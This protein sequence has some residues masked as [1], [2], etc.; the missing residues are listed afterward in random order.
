M[1]FEI[2]N[3]PSIFL[4]KNQMALALW[5]HIEFTSFFHNLYTFA[6]LLPTSSLIF[7]LFHFLLS[8]KLQFL[9]FL[10]SLMSPDIDHVYYFPFIIF[11]S[12]ATTA[13]QDDVS[14]E[15]M[16]KYVINV[17]NWFLIIIFFF[18]NILCYLKK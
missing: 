3:H 18:F 13:T 12:Y 10:P 15:Y 7:N 14:C 17:Q 5:F 8:V 16:C 1:Y 6:I 11:L 9:N 2:A 4:L